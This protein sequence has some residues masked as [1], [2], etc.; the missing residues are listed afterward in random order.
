MVL[1]REMHDNGSNTAECTAR[2]RSF[3]LQYGSM[4]TN[5][6]NVISS[7]FK[8]Q[9]LNRLDFFLEQG[10]VCTRVAFVAGGFLR[11]FT[12]DDGGEQVTTHFAHANSLALSFFSFKNQHASFENIQAT[13]DTTLLTMTYADM[14]L[15]L[16]SVPA[17]RHIYLQIIE[18]AYACQEQRNYILQNLSATKRYELLI[19]QAH[20]DILKKAFQGH[21][22]SYLGVKQ[23][24]L[25]RVRKKISRA[26]F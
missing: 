8:V 18:E 3:L 4:T 5:E 19:E 26:A 17:W 2:L 16:E 23:E 7:K 21:I 22:A 15:L 11:T 20:P 13:E 10:K 14:Q 25:S 12:T 6:W 1:G 24:T 9:H